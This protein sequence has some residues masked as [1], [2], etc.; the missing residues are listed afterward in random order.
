M[1]P[2]DEQIRNYNLKL[3]TLHEIRYII[4]APKN[5]PKFYFSNRKLEQSTKRKLMEIRNEERK[6]KSKIDVV[7]EHIICGYKI[8]NSYETYIS[9]THY[10]PILK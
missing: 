2:Y 5:I 9:W 7:D 4:T 8:Y 3:L 1:K 10:F 6:R